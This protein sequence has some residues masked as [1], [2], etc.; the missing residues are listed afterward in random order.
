M[1]SYKDAEGNWLYPDQV[2]KTSD[3]SAT[4][5]ATGAP[6]TV[7][8]IEKMSKSKRNTVDPGVIIDR[9]GA[10]TARWFVLSDNPPER[11]VEWTETGV[12]GAFRFVQRLHRLAGTIAAEPRVAMPESFAGE[13]KKL[14]QLTH[15]VIAAVTEALNSFAFNVAVARVYELAGALAGASPT[16]P[17]LLAARFEAMD[18][19]AHLLAPMMPHLAEEIFAK[20]HPGLGLAAQESW[21]VADPALLVV[22]E[23][24]IAVQVNGKLRG[25]VLLPAGTV[26]E[27]ALAI[28]KEAVAGALGEQKIVKEIYVPDRIVNFVVK[29]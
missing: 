22:D 23:V 4:H 12:Q 15:R 17:A 5:A 18:V 21:P 10:D 14:R 8:R 11:D 25:T 1:K 13:A 9:F 27:T 26:A 24:T 29:G 16:E 2:V 19:L 7:G 3:G 6:V 28:A 20:L